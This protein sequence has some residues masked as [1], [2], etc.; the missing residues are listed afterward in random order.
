MENLM[1][2]KFDGFTV[3]ATKHAWEHYEYVIHRWADMGMGWTAQK[4][5]VWQKH[6]CRKL[7]TLEVLYKNARDG[8]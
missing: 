3:V 1:G 7:K 4:Q 5:T 2:K 6:A 8:I